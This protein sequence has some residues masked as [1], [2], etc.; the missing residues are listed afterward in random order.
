[1]GKVL[2]FSFYTP[3]S[4]PL[5]GETYNLQRFSHLLN[6]PLST[7]EGVEGGRGGPPG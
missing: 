4:L 7:L 5:L 1:M 3:F 2:G 6:G